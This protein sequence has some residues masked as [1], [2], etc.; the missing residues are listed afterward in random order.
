MHLGLFLLAAG[1]HA[2]GWR[3]P[4][5][6][7]GTENFDLISRIVREAEAAKFDMVFFG[8][9]LVTSKDAH[10]SMITR[11]D[12]LVVLAMLAVQTHRIG[13][14][15]T[16]S[17]KAREAMAPFLAPSVKAAFWLSDKVPQNAGDTSSA[18]G[19]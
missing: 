3:Y 14:A 16:A 6:E 1:H 5:A 2:A 8:D 12:P 18:M 15:A 7:S 19:A 9:R 4:A 11:P 10:P 13:L 17:T